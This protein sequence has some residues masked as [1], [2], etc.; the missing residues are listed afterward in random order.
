MT[1][2]LGGVP[3]EPNTHPYSFLS[4]ELANLRSTSI[5]RCNTKTLTMQNEHPNV[6][7]EPTYH[8]SKIVLLVHPNPTPTYPGIKTVLHSRNTSG[9]Q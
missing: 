5:N 2:D 1:F 6:V 7:D 8:Y 9:P 3:I 4:V